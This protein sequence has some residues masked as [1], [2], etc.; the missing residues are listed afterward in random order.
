MV[1]ICQCKYKS[2]SN[3][4]HHDIQQ[5]RYWNC[6]SYFGRVV[7]K[8]RFPDLDEEAVA[9]DV[10]GT[11]VGTGH[12]NPLLHAAKRWQLYKLLKIFIFAFYNFHFKWCG[13]V[14]RA[15]ASKTRRPEF[16]CSHRQ[17]LKNIYPSQT[18]CCERYKF[19]YRKKSCPCI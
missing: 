1:K 8:D 16:E 10:K 6:L 14:G 5:F 15:G 3:H 7:S 11:V 9:G 13:W 12:L 4:T 19:P 2:V 18:K 17:F